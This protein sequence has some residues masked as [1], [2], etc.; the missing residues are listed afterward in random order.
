MSSMMI[1]FKV[2]RLR[3]CL[4]WGCALRLGCP[5]L[6]HGFDPRR[7]C[8]VP[9]GGLVGRLHFGAS[10]P[11]LYQA[12]EVLPRPGDRGLVGE[13]VRHV[14]GL[15]LRVVPGRGSSS[16]SA[17]TR[18]A[19]HRRRAKRISPTA[20]Q[21]GLRSSLVGF[22]APR[23]ARPRETKWPNSTRWQIPPRSGRP[24]GPPSRTP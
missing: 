8:S 3:H 24:C 16:G 6:Y 1:L 15:P 20:E 13:R 23:P 17:R 4:V 18:R 21:R 10:L 9:H 12:S 11:G 2:G 7:P 14:W 5:A 22:R 19:G